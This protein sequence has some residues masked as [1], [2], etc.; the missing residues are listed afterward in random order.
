MVPLRRRYS[1]K[2]ESK[3]QVRGSFVAAL[4]GVP[5]SSPPA[6]LPAA[7]ETQRN[8]EPQPHLLGTGKPS[9]PLYSALGQ[10]STAILLPGGSNAAV[11]AC[12]RKAPRCHRAGV[13]V[14]KAGRVIRP[15]SDPN[16]KHSVSFT[17]SIPWDLRRQ[18]G[19]HFGTNSLGNANKMSI[20]G[21]NLR[22][23][24]AFQFVWLHPDIPSCSTGRSS[25]SMPWYGK[26]LPQYLAQLFPMAEQLW[27]LNCATP[28]VLN[29]LLCKILNLTHIY[30]GRVYSPTEQAKSCF[31]PKHPA[32]VMQ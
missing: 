24:A 13:W 12:S 20:P 6:A 23:T 25:A 31:S 17:L 9:P 8:Q 4:P 32:L 28:V 7:A 26:S 16:G 22:F 29:S 21:E 5:L 15:R 10:G 19:K 27:L 18:G 14:E 2:G 3:S 11:L 1:G 30:G